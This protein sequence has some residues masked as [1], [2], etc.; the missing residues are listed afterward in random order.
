MRGACPTRISRTNIVGPATPHLG[1]TVGLGQFPY[2]PAV[3]SGPTVDKYGN[4]YV[5]TQGVGTFGGGLLSLNPDGGTRWFHDTGSAEVRAGGTIG[6]DDSIVSA[7]TDGTIFSLDKDGGLNWSIN[8]G[9]IVSDPPLIGPDGTVFIGDQHGDFF[10]FDA[11]DGGTRWSYHPIGAGGA[12]FGGPTPSPRRLRAR[13][14]LGIDCTLRPD[15][16][17]APTGFGP[18]MNSIVQD[19]VT[20]GPDNV[21]WFGT[22]DG[23]L[24]ATS[25]V[26]TILLEV[27]YASSGLSHFFN[28]PAAGFDDRVFF[29]A[30]GNSSSNLD[31]VIYSAK[32]DGGAATFHV[33]DAGVQAQ[34]AIDGA[35]NVYAVAGNALYQLG[36]DGGQRWAYALDNTVQTGIAFGAD[37]TIYVG[38][39]GGTIYAITP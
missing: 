9:Q 1:W 24:W 39:V 36:P 28:A 18:G 30:P 12:I 25:Q 3:I 31:H 29:S 23:Y 37:G 27:P 33:F 15:G 32:S 16:G 2:L 10:A 4:I 5:G 19:P 14:R 26:G 38:T 7:S 13:V 20:I 22:E 17:Q 6:A 34:L 35:G 21:V 8:V 11:I